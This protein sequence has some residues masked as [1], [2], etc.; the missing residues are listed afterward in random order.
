MTSSSGTSSGVEPA[1]P[2]SVTKRGRISVGTFTRANTVW[3]VTGSRTQHGEAQREVGDVGEG[4]ARGD[5]QRCQRGEDH[6]LEVAGELRA[7]LFVELAD[8]DD[9]DVVVGELRAQPPFEA[10]G[11]PRALLEHLLADQPERLAT[12]C[13]RPGPGVCTPASIWSCRPATRTM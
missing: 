13:G 2:A 1:A 9:V 5:R 4:P 8:A 10:V 12:A 7:A 3:S 6:L 11:Q